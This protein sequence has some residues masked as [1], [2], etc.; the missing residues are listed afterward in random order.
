MGANLIKPCSWLRTHLVSSM[1]LLLQGKRVNHA[2]NEKSNTIV[3]LVHARDV[4]F[5]FDDV[6]KLRVQDGE[7]V[8]L[9]VLLQKLLHACCEDAISKSI[10]KA[11]NQSWARRRTFAQLAVDDGGRSSQRLGGVLEFAESFQLYNLLGRHTSAHTNV[12]FSGARCAPS[13]RHLMSRSPCTNPAGE[14]CRLVR[15]SEKAANRRPTSDCLR[16]PSL[17]TLKSARPAAVSNNRSISLRRIVCGLSCQADRMR[18]KVR[19]FLF[20][21]QQ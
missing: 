1:M 4:Q 7:C 18:L 13:A 9:H 8:A 12:T 10:H 14:G 16:A 17:S 20:W 15:R 21:M 11:P 2:V 3:A 19:K 5:L 6:P